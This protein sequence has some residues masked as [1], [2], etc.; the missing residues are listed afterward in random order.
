ML[1]LRRETNKAAS[2]PLPACPKVIIAPFT[3]YQ[4]LQ[5]CIVCGARRWHAG[6]RSL[7]PRATPPAS[8]GCG[9]S[10]AAPLPSP[11]PCF[12]WADRCCPVAY[13]PAPCFPK[14][15]LFDTTA[16]HQSC[17]AYPLNKGNYDLPAGRATIGACVRRMASAT[18]YTVPLS[19]F[20][21][22]SYNRYSEFRL[23][24]RSKTRRRQ[25]YRRA[26]AQ[27]PTTPPSSRKS[28]SGSGVNWK[29]SRTGAIPITSP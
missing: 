6:H 21:Q 12:A 27:T 17:C 8:C 13:L 23:T 18:D 15:F 16:I 3:P 2:A 14:P 26:R 20:T 25:T 10:V 4:V 29:K 7:R 1:I 11:G 22:S 5:P 9:S 28:C 24:S 19:F